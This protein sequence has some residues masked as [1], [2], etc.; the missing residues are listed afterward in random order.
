MRVVVIGSEGF[1]GQ[2]LVARLVRDAPI[3]EP[4]LPATLITRLDQRMGP[5]SNSPRVRCIAGDIVERAVLARAFEGGVDYV[6][7][8]A[9]VPGGA[10]EQNF[11]LGLRVNLQ[12]TIE[13]LEA[14]RTGGHTP[15]L[16]F[17]S[18]IGVYGVPLPEVIDEQTVPAP[19]LSYGAHKYVSELLVSDYGRRGFVDGRSVRIPGIVAR[20]PTAGMYSIFLSN[21]ISELAAGQNF[22]CPVAANATSLWMSRPC[23]VDNLLHAAALPARV[24]ARQRSFL[25]PV[26]RLTIAEVVQALATVHGPELHGRISYQPDP[27]LQAQFANYPPLHC[28]RSLIVGF[29]HDGDA[30]AL[31]RRALDPP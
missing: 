14:L 16:V 20:P 26:L 5:P 9:S 22:I 21:L 13:L 27:T 19:T 10:A 12:G 2:A 29:R 17:A 30:V 31:V 18:T 1:I 8:L 25:L 24:V 23:V 6:F 7:H 15:K 3:G 4:G 28:P 11:A